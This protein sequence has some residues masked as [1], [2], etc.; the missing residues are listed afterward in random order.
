MKGGRI[1]FFSVKCV[2]LCDRFLKKAP[3]RSK[4]TFTQSRTCMIAKE[5]EDLVIWQVAID[6]YESAFG[7]TVSKRADHFE[8]QLHRAALS[9][10]NNIAEGFESGYPREFGRFL[11]ISRR[12][13]AEVRSLLRAGIRVKL[14]RTEEAEP[15][16]ERCK[17]LSAMIHRF[18]KTLPHP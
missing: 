5:F 18:L 12:S 16:I 2:V 3:F 4:R 9:I 7:L 13:C 10:S 14:I 8:D 17:V 6:V 1:A 11:R 15:L